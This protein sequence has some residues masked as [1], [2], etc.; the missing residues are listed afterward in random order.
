MRRRRLDEI[1]NCRAY[2][3]TDG[4]TLHQFTRDKSG[5]VDVQILGGND[6]SAVN[7]LRALEGFGGSG[8]SK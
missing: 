6:K 8:D 2:F 3:T 5:K 7:V 1:G 4:K